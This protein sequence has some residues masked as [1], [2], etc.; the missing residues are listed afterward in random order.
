MVIPAIAPALNEDDG[1]GAGSDVG[2]VMISDG[3][4]VMRR[5]DWAGCGGVIVS[6]GYWNWM[7]EMSDVLVAPGSVGWDGDITVCVNIGEVVRGTVNVPS[8]VD[9]P[10]IFVP[11]V[12]VMDGCSPPGP[13]AV[14]VGT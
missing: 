10:S 12:V 8:V 9:S 1:V 2:D 7:V 4:A 13:D 11:E 5:N 14:V 6:H 3:L